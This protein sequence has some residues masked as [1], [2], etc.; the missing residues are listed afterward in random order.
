MYFT[1][2]HGTYLYPVNVSLQIGK[3]RGFPAVQP[4]TWRIRPSQFAEER[5]RH[6]HF[7]E[8]NL[9]NIWKKLLKSLQIKSTDSISSV[10]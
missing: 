2:A 1:F 10:K 7:R 4:D 6:L 5:F 3:R 8:V 9:E